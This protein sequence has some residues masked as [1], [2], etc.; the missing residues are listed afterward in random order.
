MSLINFFEDM[1]YVGPCR[2]YTFFFFPREKEKEKKWN[3]SIT[4]VAK[5]WMFLDKSIVENGTKTTKLHT[6]S[7]GFA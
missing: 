4:D 7:G 5:T 6:D 3:I 2:Y 1:S